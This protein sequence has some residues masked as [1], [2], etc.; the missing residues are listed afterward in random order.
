MHPVTAPHQRI[1]VASILLLLF[2]TLQSGGAEAASY[3]LGRP[4]ATEYIFDTPVPADFAAMLTA[5]DAKYQ[6]F[7]SF[8]KPAPQ[9]IDGRSHQIVIT[10][11]AW[12]GD[13]VQRGTFAYARGGTVEV[14][15]WVQ[16]DASSPAWAAV[17]AQLDAQKKSRGNWHYVTA[18]LLVTDD[19]NQPPLRAPIPELTQIRTRLDAISQQGTVPGIYFPSVQIPA[20]LEQMRAQMLAYGNL[21]RRDPDFRRK[22]GAKTATDL[23]G[24]RVQTLGGQEKVHKQFPTP[25]YQPDA[26]LDERLNA[27]AQFQAEYNASVRRM[28]HDGPASYTDPRS[29]KSGPMRE[30]GQRREFF[31]IPHL[32]VEAAGMGAMSDYPHGWMSGDTHFR[33]WFNVHAVHPTMGYGAARGSDGQW[34]FVA[35]PTAFDTGV[36]PAELGGAAGGQPMASVPAATPVAVAPAVAPPAVP[37]AAGGEVFPVRAGRTLEVGQKIRSASGN[38]YL[39]FQADG[40]LVVYT[41]ADQYVWGLQS[42]TDQYSRIKQVQLQTDGN[43]AAYGEGEAYIWSAL[44]HDPDASAYLDLSPVGVLQLISGNTGAVLWSSSP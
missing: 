10:E 26:T 42:V 44:H 24:D 2:C 27:A 23:S 18:Q 8:P 17:A 32:V 20:A 43:L 9:T 21:G 15:W 37:A 19:A 31:G 34:H 11:L 41:A 1:G 29:G 38:H 12:D 7:R 13:K 39:V 4:T 28:S 33:P 25:P 36:V 16:M 14:G 30:L 40:N 5:S 6:A 35:V 22:N 3:Y